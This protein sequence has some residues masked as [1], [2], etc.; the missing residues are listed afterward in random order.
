MALVPLNS[1]I[2]SYPIGRE[3]VKPGSS[4]KIVPG[5]TARIVDD[6]GNEV[7]DGEVGNLEVKGESM[8]AFYS[9]Q[10]DKTKTSMWE[11]GLN[12]EDRYYLDAEGLLLLLWQRDDML[13]VGERLVSPIEIEKYAGCS[14]PAVLEIA[15]GC[16]RG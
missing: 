15:R 6:D 14:H 2:S 11:N 9:G 4:G 3:R 7:P 16:Q 1:C 13:K 10:H 12:T 5:Y 8:A